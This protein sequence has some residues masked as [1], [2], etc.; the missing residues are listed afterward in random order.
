MMSKNKICAVCEDPFDDALLVGIMDTY[1][2]QVCT[3]NMDTLMKEEL[4][5]DYK[6]GLP[7]TTTRQVKENKVVIDI[8]SPIH[9][10]IEPEPT[11]A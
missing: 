9:P 7:R 1:I 6:K 11:T 4:G 3:Q 5:D 8:Y 10:V 2:C